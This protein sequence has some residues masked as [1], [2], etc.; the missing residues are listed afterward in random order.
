MT[1]SDGM[2]WQ[3]LWPRIARCLEHEGWKG[4]ANICGP[5]RW[6]DEKARWS[7]D[8]LEMRKEACPLDLTQ[9]YMGNLSLQPS[10]S[11]YRYCPPQKGLRKC[12]TWP[13]GLG[14][15]KMA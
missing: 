11:R 10:I 14:S 15:L 1:R 5:R 12:G 6:F 7:E 3:R 13:F 2:I 9:K 4:R 8:D